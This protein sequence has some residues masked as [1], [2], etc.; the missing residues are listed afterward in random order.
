MIVTG[1]KVARFVSGALGFG[2]CPPYSAVGIERDGEI[3][4]GVLVNHFEGADCHVTVAGT[5]WTRGFLQAVGRYVFGQL[6]CLRCTIITEKP[7]V[8]ALAKRLG[9]EVEGCLRDHFG[10]GRNGT[11]I[12]I[13]AREYRHASVAR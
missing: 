7:H 5:G 9:G 1:E 3:T 2:L 12:G 8:V 4:A 6:G 11:I 13:L 10:E